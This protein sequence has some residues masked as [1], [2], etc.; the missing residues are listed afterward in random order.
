M[1]RTSSTRARRASLAITAAAAAVAFLTVQSVASPN[2][3]N[4]DPGHVDGVQ[5]STEPGELQVRP[6]ACSPG[7][8]QVV[9]EGTGGPPSYATVEVIAPEGFD[10]SRTG[11]VTFVP[12]SGVART[13][14]DV[15]VPGDFPAGQ[16]ALTLVAGD[17]RLRL[18]VTVVERDRGPG[19]NVALGQ[20]TVASSVGNLTQPCGVVDGNH[21]YTLEGYNRPPTGWA[22]ATPGVF[23]DTVETRL[24]ET[25][26][27]DRV[28]VYT[29]AE[30]R[31]ALRDFDVELHT[32]GQW[33]TAAA[34][35]GHTAG[36]ATVQFEPQ[37]ADAV[38]VRALATN[39]Y[40]YSILTEI[41]AYASG[42][43]GAARAGD[44]SAGVGGG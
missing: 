39:G 34:V 12:P 27:I 42:S 29:H 13:P 15:A 10:L 11:F 17:E 16:D 25:T 21:S 23:P 19:A 28:D 3:T 40:A 18:P 8:V 20:E 26:T 35:R 41:E 24:A 1:R 33:V 9:L 44:A 38:R 2:A 7:T 6:G 31:F 36:R 4:Q 32:G 30:A 43:D 22:D 5:V 14:L 37:A